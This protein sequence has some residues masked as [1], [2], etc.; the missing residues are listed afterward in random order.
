MKNKST[1]CWQY[2][3]NDR[4]VVGEFPYDIRPTSQLGF[5][6]PPV[7]KPFPK[8]R[9]SINEFPYNRTISQLSSDRPPIKP[10]E[11]F[12]VNRNPKNSFERPPKEQFPEKKW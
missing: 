8:D 2:F 5:D 3:P 6:R 1:S 9:P 7:G 4:F 11:R 10:F 12:P